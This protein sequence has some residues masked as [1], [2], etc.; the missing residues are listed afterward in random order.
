M[1]GVVRFHSTSLQRL[2]RR[3]SAL[4]SVLICAHALATPT[5]TVTL[6]A[7]RSGCESGSLRVT[8]E[9]TTGQRQFA[10]ASWSD[11]VHKDVTLVEHEGPGPAGLQSATIDF[12]CVAGPVP[13]GTAITLYGYLG[14]TPPTP[15]TTA[16]Y[17]VTYVCDDNLTIVSSGAGPYG[18][19][20][21][22]S[23]V[24]YEGLWWRSPPNSES[25]WG[26]NFAHQGD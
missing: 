6:D 24:N 8:A 22:A 5:A 13:F 14:T 23:A 16:E 26:I 4:V 15:E 2:T 17:A 11:L 18:T 21:R 25:G 10:R 7:A 12:P 19:V 3:A 1:F 20:S 9:G